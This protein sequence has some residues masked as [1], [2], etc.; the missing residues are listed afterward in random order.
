[1]S[2]QPASATALDLKQRT[3]PAVIDELDRRGI[4]YVVMRNYEAFPAFGHDVDFAIDPA[5]IPAWQACL[6]DL[7]PALG[8]DAVTRC[9]HWDSPY[10]HQ[11]PK[12]FS[13]YKLS[14]GLEFICLDLFHGATLWGL[15]LYQITDVLDNAVFDDRGFWRMG[16]AYENLLRLLQVDALIGRHLEPDKVQRY[17][18]RIEEWWPQHGDATVRL[19][20]HLLGPALEPATR[21]LL[22]GDFAG[23]K[24][25]MRIA[26]L[27][28]LARHGLRHPLASFDQAKARSFGRLR[29]VG[30]AQCGF[31]VCTP[32]ATEPERD[33]LRRALDI[34]VGTDAIREWTEADPFEAAVTSRERAGMEQ[35]G[36]A[37]KWVRGARDSVELDIAAFPSPE[38]LARE[39][40]RLLIRRHEHLW[41]REGVLP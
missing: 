38:A 18:G 14:P 8:W 26:R 30:R 16:P 20:R 29:E 5:D 32:D 33:Q 27:S 39:L 35:G 36:L 3:A 7:A 9:H 19:G 24:R 21:R 41:L 22:A 2:L 17:S 28:F 15:P 4:R 12:S 10:P 37:V 40:F 25:L 34:A 6:R 31:V 13:L 1:M 23:F 11:S